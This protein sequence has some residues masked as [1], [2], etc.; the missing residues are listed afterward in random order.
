MPFSFA[1]ALATFQTFI[2]EVLGDLVDSICIVF[3]DDILIY[4]DDEE[5]HMQY[6]HYVLERF[7]Q[8]NLFANLEK[9]VFNAKE[10]SF[11][12]YV[13]SP[14]GIYIEPSCMSAIQG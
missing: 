9:C 13:I 11:L 4:S 8:Y 6:V 2:N 5:E 10:V 1:N 12:G 3:L 7:K 14:K